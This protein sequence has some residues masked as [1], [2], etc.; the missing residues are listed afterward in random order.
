[1]A[2]AQNVTMN[3]DLDLGAWLVSKIFSSVL[4]GVLTVQCA[5][6]WDKYKHDRWGFKALVVTAWTLDFAN[7]ILTT[8]WTYLSIGYW[9]VNGSKTMCMFVSALAL[10]T[11]LEQSI[12]AVVS[13]V[14]GSLPAFIHFRDSF[15]DRNVG[16]Y[17]GGYGWLREFWFISEA[18]TDMFVSFTVVYALTVG[19]FAASRNGL[20]T[21][22]VA[23]AILIL[24]LLLLNTWTH[25]GLTFSTEI[26]E[27]V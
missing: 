23:V 12:M 11:Q 19:R 8:C 2:D 7:E 16:V 20:L 3:K 21:S 25:N 4:F 10:I 13:G 17:S 22:I 18:A 1:M 6:Y 15:W 14:I 26:P 5:F 27:A 9:D 24:F